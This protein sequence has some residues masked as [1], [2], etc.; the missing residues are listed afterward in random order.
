MQERTITKSKIVWLLAAAM[1]TCAPATVMNAKPADEAVT[2]RAGTLPY[3]R[4][5]DER[6]Q[7][8]QIGF[9]H[10]TGGETW[11]AFDA[12]GGQPG[13][14]IA[15]VREA[16]APTDLTNRRLRN[17]TAALAPFYLRYSGTTANNVYF[18]DDDRPQLASPPP[19]YKVVLTRQRWRDALE[20]A[21]AVNT[22]VVTSFTISHGV[23]DADHNWTPAMAAPWMAYTRSIGREIYA[24]ELYNE[25]NAPEYPELPK[26]YSVEQFGRDYATFAA[27]MAK[28][29]PAVKLAGPGN[30]TLGIPGVEAIM[31][32]SPE[33]YAKAEPKPRFGI[34]SYHFYAVLSQR[35][36]PANSP[37][38]ITADKALDPD[39]LARPERQF[40]TIKALRDQYAPGAP[41]WLTETGGAAC[42]GLQWQPTFLDMARYLDTQARLAKQGLDAIFTHALISGS[43]GVIDEKTFQPNASYWGAVL[44]RRLMGTRI[45]DAEPQPTGLHL[46]AHCLRGVPGGVSLLAINLEGKEK[47][48]RLTGPVELYALTAREPLDR[49]VLLNGRELAVTPHDTLPAMEPVRTKGRGVVLPP[50]SN[51][52]IALPN[53]HNTACH[54]DVSATIRRATKPIP[55]TGTR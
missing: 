41:I 29:A 3:V 16:R 18:Q 22:K 2:I 43:N 48:L 45:L 32:P 15:D 51:T 8:Y 47:R 4:T 7:S 50:L 25:P 27:F 30:A 37:Q 11:K 33:D 9:S 19:G 21:E 42:G 38:S 40:Q 23:R 1:G 53:A 24:A 5:T 36:A 20:F 46:Y 35:C 39:F 28:A 26:G 6:F 54:S 13:K 31:K 10:L 44:W 52:F 14:S 49:T 12:L 17:L 34:F 55:P